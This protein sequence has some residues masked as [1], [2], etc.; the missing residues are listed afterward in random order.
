MTRYLLA[1]ALLLPVTLVHIE[2][3]RLSPS[4]TKT[5]SKI[6][7]EYKNEPSEVVKVVKAV[8]NASKMFNVTRN[9]L[10]GIIAVESSFINKSL[11]HKEAC[12]YMQ[13]T[14]QSGVMPDD[15][16]DTYDNIHNGTK[17]LSGYR[18]R[19]GLHKALEAYNAGPGKR[20]TRYRKKVLA[21]SKEFI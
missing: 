6:S 5:V 9:L 21:K 8:D 4:T 18:D 1:F 3:E 16:Y 15:C 7:K 20:S 12:G 2:P 10:L 19:Y 17:L 14:K 11:S 13:L